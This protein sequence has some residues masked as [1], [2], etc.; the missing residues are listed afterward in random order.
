MTG[1]EYRKEI[2]V[3]RNYKELYNLLIEIGEPENGYGIPCY[4]D[5]SMDRNNPDTRKLR[6]I[7]AAKFWPKQKSFSIGA[8]GI[9]YSDIEFN[10]YNHFPSM[11][12]F[13]KE[14]ERMNL[15]WVQ[16][17]FFIKYDLNLKYIDGILLPEG[18]I[19]ISEQ[20]PEVNKQV[21]VFTESKRTIVARFQILCGE[22][23]EC[24]HSMYENE[25]VLA[26]KEF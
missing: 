5:Y 8:R 22:H 4:V 3:S 23:W 21:F 6:D 2:N 24:A 15:E 9:G 20:K 14:C 17:K 26:W 11:A 25:K 16:P 12:E 13:I 10:R 18:F 7:A 1:E 19:P